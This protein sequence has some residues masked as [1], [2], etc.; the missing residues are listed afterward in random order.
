M[1]V[2]INNRQKRIIEILKDT[3]EWIVSSEIAKRLH[4]SDRTV[5]NEINIIN[6]LYEEP[7][8]ISL[9]GKGYSLNKF[10]VNI[11]EITQVAEK[12]QLIIL[13]SI[14]LSKKID[15]YELA[16]KL[17]ISETTLDK[18]IS[19]INQ[20]IKEKNI[21]LAVKRKNNKLYFEG[22]EESKRKVYLYFLIDEIG[23]YSFDFNNYS[24]YFH[25]CDILELKETVMSFIKEEKLVLSDLSLISLIIHIAIML[26]SVMHGNYITSILN[27]NIDKELVRISNSFYKKLSK[28]IN[29]K[30]PDEEI[31]YIASLFTSKLVNNMD[32]L[33]PNHD[34]YNIVQNLI[35]EINANYQVDLSND[36]QF[37]N[38]LQM[39]LTALGKRVHSNRYYSNPL[40]QDIKDNFPFTYDISVYV[41]LR[42]Q[43]LM[44][45]K[46]VEDEIGFIALHM[47][48]AIEK[49]KLSSKKRIAI[50]NPLGRASTNYITERLLKCLKKPI[51]IME[52]YSLFELED[53]IRERPDLIVTTVNIDKC[54]DIPVFKCSYLLKDNEIDEIGR[55]IDLK[56]NEDKGTN[57]VLLE[58]FDKKL[59]FCNVS[60]RNKEELITHM[61]LRLKEQGYVDDRF[62]RSVFKREEIAPTAFGNLFAIPHPAEKI[63]LK[64][65]IAVCILNEGL[66]WSKHK[67]KVVFLFSLTKSNMNLNK[68][69]E[70][71]VSLLEDINRVKRLA[72]VQNYEEFID[73]ILN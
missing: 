24:D 35:K 27:D 7:L 49:M 44:D 30:L 57:K 48:C 63:A 28:I 13:K 11:E 1:V 2:N 70:V 71:F 67:V 3:N 25:A 55:L 46:L 4:L 12:R 34:Y 26:E 47:M 29:F 17:F 10:N 32:N 65:G 38:N 51:E 64:N 66:N 19:A 62:I 36:K 21:S 60:F 5:R 73:S 72:K 37:L 43:E 61:C 68:I 15:F 18:E 33:K 23:E 39:H 9:K 53:V 31:Y 59:F 42:I 8:I 52:V 58:Y 22:T 14:L 54:T 41:S 6:N 20:I 40:I 50:I 56:E 16:D 69:Y 45:I